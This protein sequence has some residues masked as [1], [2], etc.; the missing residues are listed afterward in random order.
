[1]STVTIESDMVAEVLRQA[2][3]DWGHPSRSFAGRAV[4]QVASDLADVFERQDALFDRDGF[5]SAAAIDMD[6]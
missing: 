5:V 6:A 1:M 2:R 4:R 3:K